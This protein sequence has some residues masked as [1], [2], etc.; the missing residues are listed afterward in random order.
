MW[1]LMWVE[2]SELEMQSFQKGYA[3]IRIRLVNFQHSETS[4][5]DSRFVPSKWETALLCNDVS[6]WLGANLESALNLSKKHFSNGLIGEVV[7]LRD[8]IQM[9]Y[10]EHA[11]IMI[12][13]MNIFKRPPLKLVLWERWPLVRGKINMASKEHA[14]KMAT[15]FVSYHV[16]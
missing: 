1:C 5:A 9:I 11:T 3:L 15:I 6:H 12:I 8:K 2:F 7:L 16:V 10:K 14:I 4:R 13:F